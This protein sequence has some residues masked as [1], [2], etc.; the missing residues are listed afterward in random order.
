MTLSPQ[1]EQNNFTTDKDKNE[2]SGNS[3]LSPEAL[4][5][6]SRVFN[7]FEKTMSE[8]DR[9]SCL[10]QID[11]EQFEEELDDE[12]ENYLSQD[13]DFQVL[14]AEFR[15]ARRDG[16]GDSYVPELNS[17]RSKARELIVSAL[18]LPENA[19]SSELNEARQ[20]VKELLKDIPKDPQS[21][22]AALIALGCKVK[23]ENDVIFYTYPYELFPESVNKKWENYL[24]SVETH[25]AASDKL[26]R[27]RDP[28]PEDRDAVVV[29]DRL[30]RIAHDSVT[31]DVHS[32]L[33]LD[34]FGWKEEQMRN[35]LAHMRDDELNSR[36]AHHRHIPKSNE[37]IAVEKQLSKHKKSH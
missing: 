11:T 4:A 25:V 9:L 23:T 20:R 24:D 16:R 1:M 14:F 31:K 15:K 7:A 35:L 8:R 5:F 6:A 32:I 26:A 22:E 27:L 30:R 13:P 34:E 33:S 18:N 17:R 36:Q 12:V 10:Y 21:I 2:A 37:E 29:A 19:N 3:Q 28:N